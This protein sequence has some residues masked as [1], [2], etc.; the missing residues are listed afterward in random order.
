MVF[1][2]IMLKN[3]LIL[4]FYTAFIYVERK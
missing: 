1:D 4:I 3:V 2:E